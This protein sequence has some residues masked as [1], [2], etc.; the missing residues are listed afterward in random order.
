MK[1]VGL[2]GLGQ[3]RLFYSFHPALL[4]SE[5]VTSAFPGEW[6]QGGTCLSGCIFKKQE[7]SS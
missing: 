2:A 3:G 5:V 1:E 7:L 4:F 6:G